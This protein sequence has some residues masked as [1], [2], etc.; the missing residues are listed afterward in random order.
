[1]NNKITR[2]IIDAT[3]ADRLVDNKVGNFLSSVESRKF[4]SD[5]VADFCTNFANYSLASHEG[6]WNLTDATVKGLQGSAKGAAKVPF[7][8]AKA[9]SGSS[10]LTPASW[11]VTASAGLAVADTG[12]LL[13]G[14]EELLKDQKTHG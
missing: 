7:K 8:D 10:I 12:G 9:P 4:I 6:E 2:K 5:R 11:G 3:S 1:M 13:L 14:N